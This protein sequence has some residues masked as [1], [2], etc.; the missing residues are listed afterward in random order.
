MIFQIWEKKGQIIKQLPKKSWSA[1]HSMLPTYLEIKKNIYRIFIGTRNSKGQSSIIF[2][3][4]DTSGK[5][6]KIVKISKKPSLQP[7]AL[8]SFDDNG[9]L[10][11]SVIRYKKILHLFYIGWR[12]GGT[13]RYSLIAGHAISKNNGKKFKRVNN[14]SLLKTNNKEPFE[15][16]TAPFV[17]KVNK[18]FMMW[19][20]SCNK[21]LNKDYPLYDIK[22]ATSKNLYD[23]H[24]TGNTC[25]ALKKKERAVARP[26]VVFENRK[27]KM[28]YCYENKGKNYKIGYAESKNGKKWIRKDKIIKIN[29][30]SSWDNKM[31]A[32]PN[33]IKINS[34]KYMLYNGNQYGK[35]GFGYAE[36]K[37]KLK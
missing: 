24:Q 20:V 9:V 16:L 27:F 1:S 36:L 21:W 19:Y 3:D 17:L 5:K 33:I 28:W 30:K 22:L 25:I 18:I 8:G 15:I 31:M 13:T 12:P 34:K 2:V 29:G 26:F 6:F 23:W 37:N 32:Y 35:Y 10:P 4:I 7:G 11:S 14:S